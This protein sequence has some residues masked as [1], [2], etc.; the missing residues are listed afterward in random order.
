MV[1][2]YILLKYF[3]SSIHAK[4]LRFAPHSVL[5]ESSKLSERKDVKVKISR[6]PWKSN[7]TAPFNGHFVS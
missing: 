4:S 6:Y 3:L 2:L 7:Q 5:Q 1:Y